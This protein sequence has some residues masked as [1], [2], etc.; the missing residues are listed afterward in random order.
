M[1]K[2]ISPIERSQFLNLFRA[3]APYIYQHKGKTFVICLGSDIFSTK[4]FDNLVYDLNL[5]NS[6]GIKLVLVYGVS[7]P[8]TPSERVHKNP[9]NDPRVIDLECLQVAKVAAGNIYYQIQAAFS[10][11]LPNTPMSGAEFKLISGNYIT[12]SPKGTIN[13]IDYQYAGKVRKIDTKSLIQALSDHMVVVVP[14]FGYSPTGEMFV[15]SEEILSSEIAVQLQAEKLIY[16]VPLNQLPRGG[17]EKSAFSPCQ[18][19]KLLESMATDIPNQQII[20][21][22]LLVSAEACRNGV[23]RCHLLPHSEDGSLLLEIY[24]HF[25]IGLMIV[26]DTISYIRE[27]TIE[28]IG[29]IL[30]LLQPFEEEGILV[31]RDRRDIEQ[32]IHQFSVLD[33]DGMLLATVMLDLYPQE[34]TAEMACF[35]VAKQIQGLG[36][37]KKM[38]QHIEK[39]A[40]ELGLT[41][42]FVLTT[43]TTHWFLKNGFHFVNTDWLPLDRQKKYNPLRASKIMVKSLVEMA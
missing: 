25:G 35:S 16:F 34:R 13:G 5:L 23:S 18:I 6:L 7:L 12:A 37:G 43:Q 22:Y 4:Y 24:T 20:Q 29:S 15:L 42:L 40:L 33:Y 36:E 10:Q 31:K 28:D 14:P 11:G 32:S 30:K 17:S 26:D 38:L 41:S 39:R 1:S 8:L 19:P 27:A 21:D 9:S 2:Q 3:V